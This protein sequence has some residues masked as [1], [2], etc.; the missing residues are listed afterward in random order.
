MSVPR[1]PFTVLGSDSREKGKAI[2]SRVP[3]LIWC[4]TSDLDV[5]FR[6]SDIRPPTSEL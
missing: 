1:S 2:V 6:S 4:L 3:A 5:R